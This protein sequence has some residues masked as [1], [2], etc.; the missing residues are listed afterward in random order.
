MARFFIVAILCA[1]LGAD[2]LSVWPK[3]Q[4]QVDSGK[5]YTV[6]AAEFVFS[7]AGAGGQASILADAFKRTS[8]N[9]F[10]PLFV[11]TNNLL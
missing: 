10:L 6:K 9:S 7:S 11:I 2:A 4:K 3:P 8:V 1:Q 5:L